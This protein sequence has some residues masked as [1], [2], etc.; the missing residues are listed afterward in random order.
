MSTPSA[1]R[2]SAEPH[3]DE[4]ARLPCFAT[5]APAPATTKAAAVETLNVPSPSPPVPHTSIARAAH[6]RPRGARP[7][8]IHGAG[9]GLDRLAH[10]G[11]RGEKPPR[12]RR[13]NLL[14]E[15][16]R[17]GA[18][19]VLA[20]QTRPARHGTE[21]AMGGRR[22]ASRPA[23]KFFKRRSPCGVRIDSGW[24]WTPTS[25]SVRCASPITSPS[26]LVAVIRSAPGTESFSTTSEW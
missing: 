18:P 25:G 11:Q 15:K 5:G 13:R 10:G 26:A 14:V 2:T 16:G 7:K 8:S 1:A 12:D 4:T 9:H 22:H 19:Y 21:R 24:N 17:Y 6:R 20:R 3:A 23:T